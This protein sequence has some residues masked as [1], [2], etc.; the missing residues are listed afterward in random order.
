GELKVIS[1]P[2]KILNCKFQ[3]NAEWRLEL[4]N[5]LIINQLIATSSFTANSENIGYFKSDDIIYILNDKASLNNTVFGFNADGTSGYVS[6]NFLNKLGIT[7][8][9]EI[10][11]LLEE[12]LIES[13]I[14]NT[15]LTK[16]TNM[17][18][19]REYKNDIQQNMITIISNTGLVTNV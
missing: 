13:T 5:Y 1:T 17:V 10:G 18:L 3:N 9:F 15:K 4:D 8:K 12:I 7:M 19:I 2:C 14:P 6:N 16:G 11:E